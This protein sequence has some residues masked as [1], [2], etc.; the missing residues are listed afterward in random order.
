[1]IPIDGS[2]NSAESTKALGDLFPPEEADVTLLF[3]RED[4]DSTSSVILDRMAKET[5]PILDEVARRIPQ[6]AV[7]KI[8]DF[9]VPGHVILRYAKEHAIDVILVARRSKSA[10]TT[11]MGSVATHLVK[12]AHCPVIVIPVDKVGR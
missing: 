5:M 4:I 9:G 10:L 12:H 11:L 3:V 1:M 6:Y 8:V 2:G 7:Q